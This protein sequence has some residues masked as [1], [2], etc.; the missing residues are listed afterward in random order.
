MIALRSS[1][2]TKLSVDRDFP[3]SVERSP[4]I[5]PPERI[6]RLHNVIAD[7]SSGI[8]RVKNAKHSLLAILAN[9]DDVPRIT[10]P[11]GK[12]P[13]RQTGN[14]QTALGYSR[15]VRL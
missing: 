14:A 11:R 15:E 6:F 12:Q 7:P 10:I 4:A 13:H 5:A 1:P 3:T 9:P 8:E 2:I